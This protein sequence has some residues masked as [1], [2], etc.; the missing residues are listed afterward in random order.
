MPLSGTRAQTNEYLRKHQ[1]IPAQIAAPPSPRLGLV[2]VIPCFDE[3]ALLPTLEALHACGRTTCDAEVIVVVN[4]SQAS[5][6][7]VHR[8]NRRTCEEARRWARRRSDRRLAFRVVYLPDLP[9]RHA[10][11]GLARKLGMDEAVVRLHRAGAPRGIIASLDADCSCA[12]NY[13]QALERHFALNPRS[14]GCSIHFEH[15]LDG[16]DAAHAG[17]SRYELYL[18]YCVHGLRYGGLPYAHHTVGSAMAVRCDAYQREGGMNRRKAGEDFYFLH[19][20]M[21]AGA[22]SELRDTLVIPSARASERV[23]FGTGRAVREWLRGGSDEYP[24]YAPEVFRDLGALCTAV[25]AL[26]AGAEAAIVQRRLPEPLAA[27]LADS[28]FAAKVAEIRANSASPDTFRKRFFGWLTAFRAFRYARRA[29]AGVYGWTPLAEAAGAL[30]RWQAL[31]GV[32]ERPEAPAL[33]AHY[34]RMDREGRALPF[35]PVAAAC[36]PRRGVEAAR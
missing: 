5:P 16:A 6:Q 7:A 27:Y 25:G 18:R 3:P 21:R 19:K 13:L 8:R 20:L 31:L 33:L 30:L 2:V 32:G 11:V 15:P 4:A 9:P 34:R 26:Q 1:L 28:G 24:V 12:P 35:D 10:G 17:I 14:P 29:S 22:F 36:A 23:P